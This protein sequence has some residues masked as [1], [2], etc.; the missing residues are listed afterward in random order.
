MDWSKIPKSDYLNAMIQSASNGDTI[1][2][3]LKNA[4]TDEIAS[5]EMFMKGVI[6]PIT[7]K[8]IKRDEA[9]VSYSFSLEHFNAFAPKGDASQQR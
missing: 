1:R 5:R 6:I 3:L 9:S 7:T 8:K 4:L 2:S